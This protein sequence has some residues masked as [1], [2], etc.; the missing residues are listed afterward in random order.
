M[1]FCNN[2][3]GTYT[4]PPPHPPCGLVE[5]PR[6]TF[7]QRERGKLPDIPAC[8]KEPTMSLFSMRIMWLVVTEKSP[9]VGFAV[10][11]TMT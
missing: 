8:R 10:C 9:L 4:D 5:S 7:P 11:S 1:P 6:I 3:S 2:M